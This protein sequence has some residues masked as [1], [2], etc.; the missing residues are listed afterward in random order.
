M[1]LWFIHTLHFTHTHSL[2]A[3]YNSITKIFNKVIELPEYLVTTIVFQ[4]HVS[5]M[6]GNIVWKDPRVSL[7]LVELCA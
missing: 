2:V 7:G 4:G 1:S 3:T 5:H 6:H